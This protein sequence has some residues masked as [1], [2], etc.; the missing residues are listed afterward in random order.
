[1]GHGKRAI[2][3]KRLPQMCN[4]YN[5]YIHTN[6]CKYTNLSQQ[7]CDDIIGSVTVTTHDSKD[8]STH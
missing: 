2:A 7:N 6:V 5:L 1:M 3:C 8:L 4:V